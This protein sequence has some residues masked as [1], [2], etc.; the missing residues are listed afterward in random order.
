VSE[1]DVGFLGNLQATQTLVYAVLVSILLTIVTVIAPLWIRRHGLAAID[2]KELFVAGAYFS[3]IGLGF[4]FVEIG[5]LSRLN[6]F[7]GHPT[8][9]LAV[10]LGGIITFTGV[11][12][13][14]SS[15]V[16]LEHRWLA[17]LFPL[18]PLVLVVL[19]AVSMG[20]LMHA[21]AA[22][23][24]LARIAV[25][26]GSVA[27]PALGLGICFPLGLR[28]VQRREPE[29]GPWLWALNGAFGV[30][31]SGLALGCSMAFGITT[32][33]MV[34]ALCYAV[35]PVCTWQLARK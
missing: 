29:L 21:F 7:L 8:L 4:M 14:L 11:G 16:D 26:L 30:C 28:L 20:P 2:R 17:R 31:A 5:L 34:G 12:S 35:L 27:L 22:G 6:V 25:G 9:S 3:A 15:R 33:T 18:I 19:S 24:T 1:L 23:G 32:T 13:L 10:L